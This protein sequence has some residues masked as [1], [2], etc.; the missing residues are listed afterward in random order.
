MARVIYTVGVSRDYYHVTYHMILEL[1]DLA[2]CIMQT[3]VL[4]NTAHCY[5]QLHDSGALLPLSLLPAS[6]LMTPQYRL[7]LSMWYNTFND[8]VSFRDMFVKALVEVQKR[9]KNWVTLSNN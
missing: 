3:V 9:H 7:P 1:E 5:N 8:S 6:S 2:S 4:R